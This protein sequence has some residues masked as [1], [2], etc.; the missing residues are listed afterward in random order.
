MNR[1]SNLSPLPWYESLE[2]QGFRKHWAYGK[3]WPLIAHRD[4]LLPFQ[5]IVP[6][7]TLMSDVHL[8]MHKYGSDTSFEVT[9]MM[10]AAGLAVDDVMTDSGYNSLVFPAAFP[11]DWTIQ[12]MDFN[13]DFNEDFGGPNRTSIGRYYMSLTIGGRTWYSEVMTFVYDLSGYLKLEWFSLSNL[14][15]DGGAVLY[16]YGEGNA[17]YSNFLWL[18]ADVAMPD[19]TFEEEGEERDG[20]F[21]PTKQTSE[22]TYRF[23]FLATEEICDALRIVGLS[24]VVRVTDPLGRKYLCDKFTMTPSWQPQG[25]LAS[26]DCEF[27]TDTVVIRRAQAYTVEQS[28]RIVCE[29]LSGIYPTDTENTYRVSA[30]GGSMELMF[31]PGQATLHSHDLTVVTFMMDY[32]WRSAVVTIA[33]NTGAARDVVLDVYLSGSSEPVSV[34][35][36]QDA[37]E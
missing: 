22:K 24:D 7:G 1:N 29:G 18:P 21:F 17:N 25:Y 31:Y 4:F 11:L 32:T 35:I 5:V 3:V 12:G 26:V 34:T 33:P 6:V 16:K 15:Y 27:Q 30:K 10:E 9:A 2:E 14:V 23:A 20:Y 28:R 8:R 37:A 36:S 19:Y 13:R